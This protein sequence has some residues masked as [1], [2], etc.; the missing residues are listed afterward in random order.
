ML[1]LRAESAQAA[2]RLRDVRLPS[3]SAAR[4]GMSGSLYRIRYTV[5]EV[6]RISLKICNAAMFTVMVVAE[7]SAESGTQENDVDLSKLPIGS[8]AVVLESAS[9]RVSTLLEIK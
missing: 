5:P 8:Y 7:D 1:Y 3:I 4:L 6:Q 2:A 9:A